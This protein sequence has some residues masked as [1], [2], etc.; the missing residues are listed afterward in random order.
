MIEERWVRVFSVRTDVDL[1]LEVQTPT[2]TQLALAAAQPQIGTLET[3]YDEPV[4]GQ[5]LDA[6]PASAVPGAELAA[7]GGLAFDLPFA[8]LIEQFDG[9]CIDAAL[10]IRRPRAGDT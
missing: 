10:W 9:L 1:G 2:P 4:A 6:M 3:A 7:H 8:G 5:N